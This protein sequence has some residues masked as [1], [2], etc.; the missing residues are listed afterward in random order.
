MYFLYLKKHFGL[1]LKCPM[2]LCMIILVYS[3]LSTTGRKTYFKR[4]VE[5]KLKYGLFERSCIRGKGESDKKAARK[6]VVPT[7]F[8][9]RKIE[10]ER[11]RLEKENGR[12]EKQPLTFVF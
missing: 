7:L 5:K 11:V 3:H 4:D 10:E 9:R 6:K 12:E 8:Q 1:L 2:F